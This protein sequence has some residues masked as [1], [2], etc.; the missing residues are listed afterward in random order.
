MQWM[1]ANKLSW[2]NWN[3]TDKKETTALLQPGA[4][5]TGGWAA[6]QLTPAGAFVRET[7]RQV[8]K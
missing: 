2:A 7:L 8:N 5:A 4:P 1:R 6:E 3:L